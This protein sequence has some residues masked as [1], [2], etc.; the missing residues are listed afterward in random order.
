M[1]SIVVNILFTLINYAFYFIHQ[2][3]LLI[4]NITFIYL[5]DGTLGR[6]YNISCCDKCWNYSNVV[7]LCYELTII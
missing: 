7:I 5:D 6:R 4:L 2:I 3:L 1:N